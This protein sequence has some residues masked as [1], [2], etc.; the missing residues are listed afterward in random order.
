MQIA[1]SNLFTRDDTMLGVCQALGDDFGFNPLILRVAFAVPLVWSPALAAG[2]YLALGAAVLV[3]RLII[4]EPRRAVAAPA[5]AEAPA[6]L[7]A[8]N[9]AEAEALAVAA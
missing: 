3:S 6:L 9:E 7:T 8:D 2:A 4:R 5:P 1:G